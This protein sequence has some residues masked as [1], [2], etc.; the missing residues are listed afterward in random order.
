MGSE[1]SVVICAYTEK[2]WDELLAAVASAKQQTC[3]PKEIIV[4]IDRNPALL[5]RLREMRA[6]VVVIENSATKGA[7]G[8]RN[9]GAERAQ[10]DILAFL[11]DDAVAQPD[12][13]ERLAACYTGEDIVG[14]GGRIEPRWSGK[15]PSW[16]PEEFKWV[17]GC[18]YRGLP[19]EIASV[20]NVIGANMSVRKDIFVLVGGFR[21]AFGNNKGEDVQR[22]RSKWFHHHAGDEETEFC[23]RVEQQRPGSIWLYAPAALVSHYVPSQRTRWRYFLW[24]CY[25]E[26][27]GKA[28]LVKLH[29]RSTGLSSERTYTLKT[30]PSGVAHGLADVV[31]RHDLSGILRAGAIITGLTITIAGYLIG[32][33]SSQ[34]TACFS[35]H[36]AEVCSPSQTLLAS[37]IQQQ[38]GKTNEGNLDCEKIALSADQGR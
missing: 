38:S 19:T 8:A 2:R 29:D 17:V 4:V 26:G 6:D 15:C 33:V 9:S 3:P 5:Q 16:F 37:D 32:K 36:S 22:A 27:L 31:F 34:I 13:L 35:H 11:D 25:D 23:I 20:R 1:I 14:V 7:S 28:S 30:L 24:R 21:E 18:S 12:W 10:G